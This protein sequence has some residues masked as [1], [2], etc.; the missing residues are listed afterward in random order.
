MLLRDISVDFYTG[1]STSQSLNPSI[2]SSLESMSPVTRLGGSGGASSSSI[3]P[4]A[5]LSLEPSKPL[6]AFLLFRAGGGR[7]FFR[8]RPDGG[9]VG[10]DATVDKLD[11]EIAEL[12][13]LAGGSMGGFS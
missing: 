4:E 11:W 6:A 2:S 8:T 7:G 3:L 13:L 9:G 5:R 12:D 10:L 1:R